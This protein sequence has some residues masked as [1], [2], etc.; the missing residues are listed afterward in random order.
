MRQRVMYKNK[1]MEKL[2]EMRFY[3]I[4]EGSHKASEGKI[5]TRPI[6]AKFMMK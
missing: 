3:F 6:T 4:S 2:V 1:I 5:R